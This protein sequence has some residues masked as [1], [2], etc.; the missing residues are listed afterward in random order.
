MHRYES[1][2]KSS[3][4][5]PPTA[6]S[7]LLPMIVSSRLAAQGALVVFT[8]PAPG[9]ARA[10]GWA[11]SS[12]PNNLG[13]VGDVGLRRLS[14]TY[15]ALL[16]PPLRESR[17]C[18]VNQREQLP[19]QGSDS[20][21]G[22]IPSPHLLVYLLIELPQ[23]PSQVSDRIGPLG[24]AEK[25]VGEMIGHCKCVRLIENSHRDHG[26]LERECKRGPPHAERRFFPPRAR[27]QIAEFFGSEVE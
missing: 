8:S 19:Q 22:L 17:L 9:V 7:V 26:S 11:E 5:T 12:K 25:C 24:Q 21:F 3:P 16:S 4:L 15:G 23:A 1:V 18:A 13:R 27:N 6:V 14:P 10:V 2:E 20:D